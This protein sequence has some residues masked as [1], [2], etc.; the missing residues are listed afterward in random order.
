MTRVIA[1]RVLQVLQEAVY[2]PPAETL[3]SPRDERKESEPRAFRYRRNRRALACD[4]ELKDMSEGEDEEGGEEEAEEV[5]L[6][7]YDEYRDYRR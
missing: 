3:N 7:M 2:V 5:P 4:E 6:E 1:E